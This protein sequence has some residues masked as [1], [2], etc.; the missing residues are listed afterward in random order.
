VPF[1]RK[2]HGNTIA[3]TRPQFFDQTVVEFAAPLAAEE[4]DDLVAPV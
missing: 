1:V 4:R 2:A 3:V